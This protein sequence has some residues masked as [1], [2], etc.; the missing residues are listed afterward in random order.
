[1]IKPGYNYSKYWKGKNLLGR[2]KI[3]PQISKNRKQNN[4]VGFLH[5]K[6]GSQ[7]EPPPKIA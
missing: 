4:N 7:K 3:L 5:A 2:K 6:R 1:M